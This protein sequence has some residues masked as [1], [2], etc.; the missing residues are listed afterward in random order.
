MKEQ[1]HNLHSINIVSFKVYFPPGHFSESYLKLCGYIKHI[2]FA[3]R[4][5]YSIVLTFSALFDSFPNNDFN[6]ATTL[7]Q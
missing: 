3:F 2:V 6:R 5:E 7:L 4:N 1:N